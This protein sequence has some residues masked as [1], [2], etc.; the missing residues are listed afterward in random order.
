[1]GTD[2]YLNWDSI[3]E[4]EQKAQYT[5]FVPKG[6]VGYLRASIGMTKENGLLRQI[7]PDKYWE[8]NTEYG[9]AYN[10]IES[11]EQNMKY[12]EEYVRGET[13][14]YENPMTKVLLKTLSGIGNADKIEMPT[15]DDEDMQERA[16]YAET[17]I[18]FLRLGKDRQE[19]GL[20][21][22]VII[23]W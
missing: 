9:L 16:M 1:M 6:E 2:I 5:G 3:T 15:S 12:I 14:D 11:W 13:P 21:P 22:T 17:V 20:N 19:K 23:S 4:D 10:F 8:S 18:A 7:F